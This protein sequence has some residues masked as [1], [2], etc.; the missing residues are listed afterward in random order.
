ME[1][2][3]FRSP[4]NPPE[5]VSKK[6]SVTFPDPSCLLRAVAACVADCETML[7]RMT[8]HSKLV[9]VFGGG[10]RKVRRTVFR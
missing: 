3:T 10:E 7:E 1:K 6:V 9:A 8:T 2:I 4:H 5:T